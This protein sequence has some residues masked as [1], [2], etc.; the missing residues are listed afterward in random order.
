MIDKVR[1]EL[2]KK[3]DDSYDIIIG[4]NIFSDIATGLAKLGMK[5][6]AVV[7]DSNVRKHYGDKFLGMLKSKKI[8]ALMIS[9]PAGEQNKTRETKEKIE[10]MLISNNFSRD[11]VIIALGGGVI[12]D[13]AG[14]VASTFMRGI[15]FL[16]VPT[17]LLAMIDSSIGG[18]T[19]VDTKYG[20][21]LIGTFYHPKRVFID[22]SVLKTLPKEELLNGVA[23]M[24]KHGVILDR[25]LFVFIEDY[26][27]RIL[28]L[29]DDILVKC[30]KWNL[31]LKKQVVEKDE[32]ERSY[33]RILN[34]G[35]TIGHAVEKAAEYNITHGQAVA[36]GMI[37][38]TNISEELGMINTVESRKI[39]SL[40]K[41]AGFESN[42]KK[43]DIKKIMENIK[44]DKKKY[45]G[46][47]KYTL[48]RKI[49]KADIDVGI[50]DE[51]ISK[52]LGETE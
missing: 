17:T 30:I 38:E 18:K 42:I 2:I 7:T 6:I 29:E 45:K 39:Y 27:D 37:A 26:I 34:F 44:Y 5:K 50:K 22:I 8:D 43:Y 14:F 32:K 33:R 4:K 48:P 47:V 36:L 1:L 46:T 51:V 49:G 3:A 28:S 20:K 24:I 40:I 11:S 41:K 16:Q 35:H 10:D 15:P 25:K 31:V 13:L 21:N 23:E 52:V 12:G 9:I 19:A